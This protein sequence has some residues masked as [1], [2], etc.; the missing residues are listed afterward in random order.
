MNPIL[1]VVTVASTTIVLTGC[2]SPQE[3]QSAKSI[4]QAFGVNDLVSQSASPAPAVVAYVEPEAPAP[5]WE[6]HCWTEWHRA[7]TMEVR[8]CENRLVTP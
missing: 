8:V 2:D 1:A 4:F 7:G 6:E 3:K 5:V